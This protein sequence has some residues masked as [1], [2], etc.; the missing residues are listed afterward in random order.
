MSS[1]LVTG[2]DSGSMNP[3]A[4]G[5]VRRTIA[6]AERRLLLDAAQAPR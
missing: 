4:D 1:T 6:T 5:A 3:D 2:S